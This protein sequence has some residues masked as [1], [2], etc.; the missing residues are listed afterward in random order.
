MVT[1][2]LK[3]GLEKLVD[4]FSREED[5][6]PNRTPEDVEGGM[7]TYYY[8]H[9]ALVVKI[10]EHL[11]SLRIKRRKGKDKEDKK[12]ARTGHAYWEAK[13]NNLRNY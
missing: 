2:L 11:A 8:R 10:E 7:E 1:D 13:F 3:G 6:N 5:P 4:I 12:N 9:P